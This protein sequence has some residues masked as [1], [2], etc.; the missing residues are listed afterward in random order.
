[1]L[2]IDADLCS[3]DSSRGEL[4]SLAAHL[5]PKAV[6]NLEAVLAI[7][8]LKVSTLSYCFKKVCSSHGVLIIA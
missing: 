4:A 1:M 5:R 7:G 2:P 8:G 6:V 3:P